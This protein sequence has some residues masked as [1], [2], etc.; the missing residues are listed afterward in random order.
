MILSLLF[1]LTNDSITLGAVDIISTLATATCFAGSLLSST[2]LRTRRKL[3][4]LISLVLL[5]VFGPLPHTGASHTIY[6]TRASL[7]VLSFFAA[8]FDDS[9]SRSAAVSDASHVHTHSKLSFVSRFLLHHG[10]SYPL[11]ISILKRDDSR[12]IFYFMR[13]VCQS[14]ENPQLLT[15]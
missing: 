9:G 12:R 11:L 14:P 2:N 7:A 15:V 3:G 8:H 13:Y 5:S 1:Y 4:Y 6:F 10:Q